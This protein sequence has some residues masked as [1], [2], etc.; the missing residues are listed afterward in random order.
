MSGL[1]LATH[2][3]CEA[4][5]WNKSFLDNNIKEMS[6]L[7]GILIFSLLF[8]NGTCTAITILF[9]NNLVRSDWCLYL[10]WILTLVVPLW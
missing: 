5:N 3:D 2:C 1:P 4:D 9:N 6:N 7:L 10:V 8:N